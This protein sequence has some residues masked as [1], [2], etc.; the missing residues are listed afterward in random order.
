MRE[1]RPTELGLS[2]KPNQSKDLCPESISLLVFV[3]LTFLQTRH[4]K[5]QGRNP[6]RAAAMQPAIPQNEVGSLHE[7]ECADSI[8]RTPGPSSDAAGCHFWPEA[9]LPYPIKGDPAM[10]AWARVATQ[11]ETPIS[12]LCSGI[13]GSLENGVYLIRPK[14]VCIQSTIQSVIWFFGEYIPRAILAMD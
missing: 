6:F 3:S 4:I 13:R 10:R 14:W 9:T 12:G 7:P 11:A 5:G 1:S 8:E 2:V